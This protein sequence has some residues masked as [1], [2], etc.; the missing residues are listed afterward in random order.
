MYL[1]IDNLEI[2][3]NSEEMIYKIESSSSSSYK[4]KL[5]NIIDMS[6]IFSYCKSL[7]FL[8][9]ISKWNT[10]K[11]KY[12]SFMFSN[13]HSLLSIPS[14]FNQLFKSNNSKF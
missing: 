13:C 8:P 11:I 10:N 9:D 3:K 14:K 4:L 1:K 12:M 7:S 6:Y 2:N 5:N